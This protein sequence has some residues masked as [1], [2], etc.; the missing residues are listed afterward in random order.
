MSKKLWFFILMYGF[1]LG[2]LLS[3]I[4]SGPLFRCIVDSEQYSY[5]LL[6]TIMF[7]ASAAMFFVI[8]K[9]NINENSKRI[10][11][12]VSMAVGLLCTIIY[13]IFGR[14]QSTPTTLVVLI[15]NT[16]IAGITTMFFIISSTAYF[17]RFVPFNRIFKSMAIIVLIANMI[18]YVVDVLI[19]NNLV[20]IA[21]IINILTISLSLILAYKIRDH[22]EIERIDYHIDLPKKSLFII[23]MA[24]FLLNIGGG[25]V[26]SVVE[27]AAIAQSAIAT[28]LY[29]LPYILSAIAMMMISKRLEKS[30]DIL[31]TV[32]AGL[33]AIG[34]LLFQFSHF[35]ALVT[36][37]FIQIGYAMLDIVLWGLVGQM[38]F[39]YG[40]PYKI[41][42]FTMASNILAVYLGMAGSK[43][44]FNRISD[45]I[46]AITLFA[47]VCII[48]AIMAM[49]FIHRV[50]IRDMKTGLKNIREKQKKIENLNK[51]ENIE[52]LTAREHEIVELMLT[53]K[54]NRE[55]AQAL[56]ISENTLKTH[57]KNIY[58][59]LDVKN[60]KALQMLLE[61]YI[62]S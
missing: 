37:M 25:V 26:F 62:S 2:W 54:T 44:L 34:L 42:S 8:G 45:P 1:F 57:A 59:K 43:A 29:I 36:N 10:I 19:Q 48:V 56:Y 17:I 9:L 28:H 16:L 61:A 47:T 13:L 32:A 11:M 15:I 35:N 20:V 38:S 12:P 39:V 6:F 33:V 55:I 58:A 51:I 27:P 24:F 52:Q 7:L 3:F 5:S 40:Q 21:V 53:D 30:I 46:L 14:T 60:K 31:L 49:P 18:V 50:T 23:C 41:A 22:E 4:Y